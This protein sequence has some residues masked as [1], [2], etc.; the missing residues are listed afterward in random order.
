MTGNVAKHCPSQDHLHNQ[1][2]SPEQQYPNHPS[3]DSKM[4][5]MQASNEP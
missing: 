5:E 1:L 4:T 3:H 2:N